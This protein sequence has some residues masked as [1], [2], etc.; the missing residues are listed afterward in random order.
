ML[1]AITFDFWNTLY[2]GPPDAAVSGQRALDVQQVLLAE[3]LQFDLQTLSD[4]FKSAWREA[5]YSQ[6]VYGRDPGPRG[7][8]AHLIKKLGIK[9]LLHPDDLYDAYTTTLLKLPPEINDGVPETLESLGERMKLAVIC[10]TGATP[11]L[12]LRQIMKKD[13]LFDYFSHLVFSDEVV[14][15]KPD[16]GIFKLTVKQLGCPPEKSIHI[17]DDPITDVIG[18]KRAGMKAVWLA[19]KADWR[20]PEADYHIKEVAELLNLVVCN[21]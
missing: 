9:R 12:Y 16:P 18:A 13:Q 20:L 4:A 17:G 5:Y 11:G 15:A 2:K 8:V 14:C 19:P 21:T 1:L 10:N 6:R 3:G 7:Q